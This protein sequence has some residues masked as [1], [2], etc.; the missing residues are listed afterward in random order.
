MASSSAA[1]VLFLYFLGT[2]C[3]FHGFRFCLRRFLS[4]S[5][6]FPGFS[7]QY[8]LSMVSVLWKEFF[9]PQDVTFTDFLSTV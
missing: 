6:Y 1:G 3:T 8:K 7:E 4:S 5:K 2:T 9:S